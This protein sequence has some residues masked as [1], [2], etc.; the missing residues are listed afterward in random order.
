[1]IVASRVRAL[2]PFGLPRGLEPA[3]SDGRAW[4]QLDAERSDARRSMRAACRLR[5]TAAADAPR[6][7]GGTRGS[8]AGWG[9][10]LMG[11]Q[12][13]PVVCKWRWPL[14]SVTLRHHDRPPEA[15]PDTD[16][17]H[18]DMTRQGGDRTADETETVHTH[19]PNPN[20]NKLKIQKEPYNLTLNAN[21]D[22]PL[23]PVPFVSLPV[24]ISF[25]YLWSVSGAVWTAWRKAL[26]AGA[27]AGK[28]FVGID[29]ICIV[30]F[31]FGANAQVPHGN[32][33]T[34]FVVATT[35]TITNAP[36][37]NT[38]SPPPSQCEHAFAQFACFIRSKRRTLL[39]FGIWCQHAAH[40]LP[41][42]SMTE[43]CPSVETL[44]HPKKF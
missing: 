40:Y 37:D 28:P 32:A 31:A 20:P 30:A 4:L 35:T 26:W 1:M 5:L 44:N 33:S 10:V 15:V 11:R 25:P 17:S 19:K 12:Q 8:G 27:N 3:A 21:P 43:R 6:Q 16:H 14:M 42:N 7:Q 34:N 29:A 38:A 23:S 39:I 41:S 2:P 36:A 13:A 24:S 22:R 18:G 9:R